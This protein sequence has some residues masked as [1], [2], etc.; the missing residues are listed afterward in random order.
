MI[1]LHFPLIKCKVDSASREA[2]GVTVISSCAVRDNV[3]A[4][5]V[6]ERIR[7][8]RCISNKIILLNY[9]LPMRGF[10]AIMKHSNTK[11]IQISGDHNK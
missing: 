10:S 3:N 8:G 1:I 5:N 9:P 7:W 2:R 4:L 11:T 6:C